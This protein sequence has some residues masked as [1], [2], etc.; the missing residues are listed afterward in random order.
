M[1]RDD[2]D[3]ARR[4]Q[5]GGAGRPS[6]QG[7][8]ADGWAEAEVVVLDLSKR[9]MD[10]IEGLKALG[11][12]KADIQVMLLPGRASIRTA[13]KAGRLGAIDVLG[14]PTDVWLVMERIREARSQ[15]VAARTR[16]SQGHV[17]EM[18]GGYGW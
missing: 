16:R 9:G 13:M 7:T 10:E 14:K 1:T 17:E 6:V 4:C 3:A 5:C 12:L 8:V 15:F 18:L 11:D 2:M